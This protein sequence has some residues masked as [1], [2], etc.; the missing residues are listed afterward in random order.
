MDTS[1]IWAAY[2]ETSGQWDNHFRACEVCPDGEMD[3]DIWR[4]RTDCTSGTVILG[5]LKEIE[6]ALGITPTN[7]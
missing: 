7:R 4:I 2:I 6:I 1:E 3:D 5:S